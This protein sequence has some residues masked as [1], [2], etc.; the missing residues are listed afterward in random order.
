MF[1]SYDIL[2]YG[3]MQPLTAVDTMKPDTDFFNSESGLVTM[4]A[5]AE[6]LMLEQGE[7]T[8]LYW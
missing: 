2:L 6:Q 1:G 5:E 7:E 3:E 8:I 4:A